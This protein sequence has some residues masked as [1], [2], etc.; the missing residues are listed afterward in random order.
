MIFID[1]GVNLVLVGSWNRNIFTPDWVA[2]NI[3][4]E[5][6]EIKVEFSINYFD[7]PLRLSQSNI[8]M[9]TANDRITFFPIKIDLQTCERIELMVKNLCELLPH[10][11]ITAYGINFGVSEQEPDELLLKRF[12]FG[13]DN[14][15]S[16]AGFLLSSKALIRSISIDDGTLNIKAYFDN[17]KIDFDFNFHFIVNGA[18]NVIEKIDGKF[19]YCKG[20]VQKILKDIYSCSLE[21]WGDFDE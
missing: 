2:K 21:P 16:D 13:D 5:S 11:P 7:A 18:T 1:E 8:M 20:M 3:F 4:K 15:F 12:N 10:T 17:G 6:N 14:L 9:V 19:N